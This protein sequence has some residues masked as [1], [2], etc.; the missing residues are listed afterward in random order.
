MA[1]SDPI[2]PAAGQTLDPDSQARLELANKA[3][4]LR[5]MMIDFLHSLEDKKAYRAPLNL[6]NR[7]V[8]TVGLFFQSAPA[9]CVSL[10]EITRM[11][12]AEPA[13]DR[14]AAKRPAKDP[15]RD[16]EGRPNVKAIASVL[17]NVG[18]AVSYEVIAGW[19]SQQVEQAL[20]WANAVT[21]DA[22]GLAPERPAF[23][24]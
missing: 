12:S 8:L 16:P 21:G 6:L 18:V 24:S 1:N 22:G 2:S 10:K 20:A 4:R 9:V 17:E 3:F 13:V 11:L 23:L 5:E 15:F 19:D 7:E 14:P